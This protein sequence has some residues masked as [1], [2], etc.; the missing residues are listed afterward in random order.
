MRRQDGSVNFYRE[1]NDYKLGFGSL[2]GEFWAGSFLCV[3]CVCAHLCVC[4]FVCVCVRVR[5]RTST[6][7]RVRVCI[8]MLY[9]NV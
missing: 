4:V 6:I 2:S 8:N 5:A 3:Y 7:T 9:T 1:W